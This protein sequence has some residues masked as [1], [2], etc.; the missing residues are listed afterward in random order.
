MSRTSRALVLGPGGVPGTAWM[1]GLA[2]GLRHRGVDLAD[3]DLI[4]GTSAG[5]IVGAMLA[6]GQDLDRL[7]TRT[8][9]APHLDPDP[10]PDPDLALDLDL[11]QERDGRSTASQPG[12]QTD[13]RTDPA[14]MAEVFTVLGD[15]TLEPQEALRRV[16][17]IAI[18]APTMLEAER[19]A[20]ME[21]LITARR[22]PDRRL[23]ITAVNAETGEPEVWDRDS[24]APLVAAVAASSAMP[25]AYPPITINGHRYID[26]ALAGGTNAALATG[27]RVVLLVEPLA[28]LFPREPLDGLGA[29]TTV[30]VSPDAPSLKAFG[31]DM[32]NMASW[33]P[34]FHAGVAQ[35]EQ[36]AERL[37]VAWP[38]TA[39]PAETARKQLPA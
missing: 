1:A 9:P 20:L 21:S 11:R 6:T 10:D 4:V 3:A 32:S 27:A 7:A 35:A 31:S 29:D 25:G 18:E 15:P 22:W 5:A 38:A 8:G 33:Q 39:L 14:R 12:P 37:R 16:G 19:I 2:A 36:E 24:G 13:A 28:H 23:L 34:A 30:A 26:G 17:R